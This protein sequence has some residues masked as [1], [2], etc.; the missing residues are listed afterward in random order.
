MKVVVDPDVCLGCGVC[1]SIAPDIFILRDEL[2]AHIILDPVPE[3][4]RDIVDEAI[5]EC[6][7]K[8]IR[9]ID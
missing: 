1:E 6:P 5:A 7:E 8:A 9:L 3:N 2:F 4:M